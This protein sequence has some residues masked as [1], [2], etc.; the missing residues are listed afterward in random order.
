VLLR[1]SR[2][3]VFKKIVQRTEIGIK[4]AIFWNQSENRLDP[5]KFLRE[6]PAAQIVLRDFNNSF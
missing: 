2:V 5:A 6:L 1:K 4:G 3:K